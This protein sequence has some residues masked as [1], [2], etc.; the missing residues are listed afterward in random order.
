M[1]AIE[2]KFDVDCSFHSSWSV[3]HSWKTKSLSVRN[4]CA[5]GDWDSGKLWVYMHRM[6]QKWA[7][8]I[9]I[10]PKKWSTKEE[11]TMSE[12]CWEKNRPWKY[13]HDTRFIRSHDQLQQQSNEF[14]SPARAMHS[15][16]ETKTSFRPLDWV[17]SSTR[18]LPD[19]D[20]KLLLFASAYVALP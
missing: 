12:M 2:S 16:S 7:L 13:G 4:W 11:W 1:I 18:L 6:K 17:D 19:W 8:S 3:V 9:I 14:F 15:N 10:P 5:A 20:R